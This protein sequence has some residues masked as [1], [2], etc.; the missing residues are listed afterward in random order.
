MASRA[1]PYGKGEQAAR[2]GNRGRK[3]ERAKRER[4][5]STLRVAPGSSLRRRRQQQVHGQK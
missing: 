5:R 2:R 3:T 1:R 4:C